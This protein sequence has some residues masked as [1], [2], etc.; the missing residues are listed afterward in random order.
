M[1]N[2][3]LWIYGENLIEQKIRCKTPGDHGTM[4]VFQKDRVTAALP[5]GGR[6]EKDGGEFRSSA[7]CS[8]VYQQVRIITKT[9]K[10]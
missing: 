4:G 7:V 10:H 2:Q 6:G 1:R 9:E 8:G 3:A 5:S